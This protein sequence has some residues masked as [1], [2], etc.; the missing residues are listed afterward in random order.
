MADPHRVTPPMGID[1]LLTCIEYLDRSARL[2]SELRH[3]E[4]EVEGLRFPP[5]PTTDQ[6]LDHP[7]L[8]RVEVEHTCELTVQVVRDLG[9]RPDG[10]FA[11]GIVLPD[12][13]VRLDRGRCRT[14]EVTHTP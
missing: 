10:E 2:Q 1:D 11:T 5:E 9:R 6:G 12:R 8:G 13:A 3:T 14:P 4:L 7:D